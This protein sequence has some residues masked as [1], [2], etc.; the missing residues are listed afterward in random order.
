[1]SKIIFLLFLLFPAAAQADFIA[2]AGLQGGTLESDNSSSADKP[3]LRSPQFGFKGEIEF[4]S[5]YITAF[6]GLDFGTGTG[7]IQYDFTNPDDATDTAT[8]NNLKAITN[9]YRL[10]GGLRIRLI[11]LKKFRLYVG[12]GLHVGMLNVTYDKDD[13]K[14]KNGS[15]TGFEDAERNNLNGGFGELGMEIIF[16]ENSG[17]RLSAQR[18][19]LKTD[20]YETIGNEELKFNYTS[21][22]LSYIEYIET[23]DW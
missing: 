10:S 2:S 6:G 23:S 18:S 12:G 11:K 9:L 14:S 13:F 22:A 3:L 4:G 7:R 21:Y 20:K 1:M 16:T 17:L 19:S 8:V 5:P 15:T